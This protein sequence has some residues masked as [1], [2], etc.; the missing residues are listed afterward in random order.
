MPGRRVFAAA[1]V[2]IV[3]GSGVSFGETW[4]GV[5]LAR[6]WHDAAWKFGPFRIQPSLVISNAGVD[7][8][9]YYSTNEPIKDY[10][11]TAGPAAILYVPIHRKFVLSLYGSPQY[12][13]YS[14]T[15]R[16]RTWNYY[17]S[18][19]AQ[20]SLKNVFF[21]LEGIYSDARERWNTEIDIR[22]RR[23]EEGYGGSVLVKTSRKTSVSLGYRTVKYNYESVVYGDSFD[24][25]ERLNRQESYAN[26]SFFYQASTQR[27]FFL[28]FEYGQYEFDFA[29]QA[30]IGD[31]RSAAAYAGLD[32]S[33]LGRRVRGR[34][35]VG[36]KKFDIRNPE[37]PD[38]GGVVG[39]SQL[40]VRLA[41]PF[42]I[43]GSY[44]RDVRFSLWYDNPYY[45]ESRP[46]AGV[47]LY[48]LRFL[49]LDYDY[50]VG[51]NR[52]PVVGGGGPDV[53]RLDE[54]SI[55]SA[56]VYFRIKKTV[57]LGFIASLWTR[58]SNLET[59]DDRR[60]FFGLNLTYDF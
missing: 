47:S 40:S 20:L 57:A 49:R 17:F 36:Y 8:N 18:G 48:L 56:A 51:R 5:E 31:S 9:L 50:S 46:G 26:F 1:I 38:N 22:P 7:S 59:E 35:R 6:K 52:Y 54:Y 32:L 37:V 3:A 30:A 19:A 41:K 27:R 34:I 15:D 21:S 11:V 12:V 23:K 39:D 45:V 4:R 60:T 16:E 14:K 53:K 2:L 58:N 25:R 55:H 44:V 33:R 24:V 10:T 28:D 42:V 13:W 43:R 29:I